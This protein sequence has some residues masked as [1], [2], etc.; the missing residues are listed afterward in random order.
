MKI[1]EILKNRR[2][3]FSFEFFPPNDEA[4]FGALYE[5]VEALAPLAP[6][7]VSVTYGAG[8]STRKKTLDLV[9]RIKRETGIETMA[10]LTCVD[11]TRSEIDDVLKE[12]A[13]GGVENV[14][15]LRG[16]PPQGTARFEPAPGGFAHASELIDH[17]K[18]RYAFC[19][20]AAGYPEKHP[21]AE[22]KSID[23]H[24]L[25]RKVASGADFLITQLFFDNRHFYDFRAAAKWLDIKIPIVAGIMPVLSVKQVKKFTAMCGATIPQG[26]RA[27]LEENVDDSEAVR[28]IGMYHATEQCRALLKNEA[29]GI[30]FYTLNKST[31]TRA[32]WSIL[33]KELGGAR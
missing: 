15:A 5:S 2:P 11:A 31:A 13:D 6:D 22:S 21:E 28:Q 14:L 17:I 7:F 12:L 30:H 18:S 10:H 27:E 1:S 25:T 33:R 8:G 19:I 20:G 3:T 24:N 32:I 29:A 26:L 16:D 9:C 4:G 23:I